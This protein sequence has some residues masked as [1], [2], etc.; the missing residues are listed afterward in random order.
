MV[1]R[2]AQYNTLGLLGGIAGLIVAGIT[3]LSWWE[4]RQHKDIK[5]DLLKLDKEIKELELEKAKS[6]VVQVYS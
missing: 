2:N 4:G 5:A 3:F 1:H 6:E